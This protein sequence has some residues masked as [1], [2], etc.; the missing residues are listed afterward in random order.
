MIRLLFCTLIVLAGDAFLAADGV[1]ANDGKAL[2]RCVYL[3]DKIEHY[4][5][6]RRKGGSN[7]QMASWRKS[8]T[9]YEEEFRSARCRQF[10]HSLRRKKVQ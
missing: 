3:D 10:S 1:A 4:T 8:R 7:T 2:K 6:L 9:R 5:A